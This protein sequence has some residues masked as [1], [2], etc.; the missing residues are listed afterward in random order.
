MSESLA[1]GLA[2]SLA[3]PHVLIPCPWSKR[4]EVRILSGVPHSCSKIRGLTIY[5]S[6]ACSSRTLVFGHFS[7]DSDTQ[8]ISTAAA[9]Q[10]LSG[11]RTGGRRALLVLFIT[12]RPSLYW[13]R[14]SP[15]VNHPSALS[16]S[17]SLRVAGWRASRTKWNCSPGTSGRDTG[18]RATGHS[19]AIVDLWSGNHCAG[20]AATVAKFRFFGNH[21]APG[22]KLIPPPPSRTC[23]TRV[24]RG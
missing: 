20:Y 2:E 12:P 19:T 5:V 1:R 14:E 13:T 4:S 18:T 21:S 24:A 17:V 11:T 3:R 7:I 16:P 9:G 22:A 6:S 15:Q 8:L 23:R 10:T